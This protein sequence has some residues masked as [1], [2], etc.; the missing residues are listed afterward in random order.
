MKQP[1][2]RLTSKGLDQF[3]AHIEGCKE[4]KNN[5]VPLRQL[6]SVLVDGV[7]QTKEV[8]IEA[9]IDLSLSFAT[10]FDF[11]KYIV[12]QIGAE[13]KDE[14]AEDAGFWA[15]LAAAYWA[16]FTAKGVRRQEHYI[17]LIGDLAGKL[18]FQRIDYRHCARTPVLL[19]RKLGDEAKLFLAGAAK[20]HRP[21]GEMGDFVEQILSRQD[22]YGNARF[23]EV[24]R[25]LYADVDGYEKVGSTAAPKKKKLKN[26]KWSK[27]GR[28][29]AR[30]LVMGVLPR[31]KLTYSV[32]DLTADQIV[33]LAGDEFTSIDA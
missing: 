16:Q 1:L 3:W 7:E 10:R 24:L 18:G 30:R 4:D 6:P 2:R 15:W 29:G 8:G 32:N 19:F 14:L 28:G 31:L 5:G 13:W 20:K 25:K 21:M 33:V 27:S 22:V 11:A 23:L 12:G 17:P 9:T 26:G